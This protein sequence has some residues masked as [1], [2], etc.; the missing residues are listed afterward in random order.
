MDPLNLPLYLLGVVA[1]LHYL[2]RGSELGILFFFRPAAT[3][4]T[5]SLDEFNFRYRLV[6][7]WH[8]LWMIK[9]EFPTPPLDDPP[10]QL[11]GDF[12]QLGIP[13]WCWFAFLFW[14]SFLDLMP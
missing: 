6:R 1:S 14:A 12:Q 10:T 4:Q 2:A 11:P 7:V 9:F 5:L 8:P 3:A 13:L